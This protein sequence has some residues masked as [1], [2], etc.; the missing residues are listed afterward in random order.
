MDIIHYD[1]CGPISV[2]TAGGVKY[3]LVITD[4]YSRYTWIILIKEK[5]IVAQKLK[6]F[7]LNIE[8]M[9]ERKI[10]KFHSD[11]CTEFVNHEL[12]TFFKAKGISHSKSPPH[13]P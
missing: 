7:I 9:T 12:E 10:K 3:I 4:D 13:T 2:S 8:N 6:E 11:N 5:S 1:L